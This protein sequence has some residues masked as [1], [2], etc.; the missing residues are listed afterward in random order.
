MNDKIIKFIR[1][2]SFTFAFLLLIV[3]QLIKHNIKNPV[4]NFGAGFGIMQS[5]RWLLIAITVVIIIALS[6]LYIKE[7]NYAIRLSFLLIIFGALSNVIDRVLLGYVIDYLPFPFWPAFP[8]Y[9]L[10]D[11]MICFGVIILI[12]YELFTMRKKHSESK[13]VSKN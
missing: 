5:Q 6:Y 3:D 8:T 13:D 11:S 9:N 12:L 2:A 10:G 4:L 1:N 7:K